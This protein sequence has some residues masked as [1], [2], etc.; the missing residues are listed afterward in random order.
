MT[1][2]SIRAAALSLSRR[3]LSFESLESRNLLAVM[4]IVDWNTLNGPNDATGD[5]NFQT[6]LQAIGTETVQGNTKRIDILALQE[7]DPA[8][9]GGNSIGRIEAVLDSLYPTASYSLFATSTDG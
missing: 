6:V 7:T 4:R 2:R 1:I 3:R 8:G 9:T 5:A